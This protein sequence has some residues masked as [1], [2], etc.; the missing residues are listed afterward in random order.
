MY[1][2]RMSPILALLFILEMKFEVKGWIMQFGVTVFP[3][4]I[5]L[6]LL[7]LSIRPEVLFPCVFILKVDAGMFDL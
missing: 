6:F 1:N 4:W 2:L 7:D 5:V 3:L